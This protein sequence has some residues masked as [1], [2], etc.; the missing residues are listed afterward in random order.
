MT[1]ELFIECIEALEKQSESDIEMVNNLEK[2][3]P[4]VFNCGDLL[5]DNKIEEMLIKVLKIELEDCCDWIGYYCYEL[6]FGKENWRLKV[7]T[8]E[9][10]EIPLKTAED[11][12]NLLTSSFN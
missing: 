7:Y 8:K 4:N 1:K 3:F 12:Y 11:L 9:G 2:V 5:P 6:D 10:D